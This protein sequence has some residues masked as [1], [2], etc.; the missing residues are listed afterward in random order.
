MY[1]CGFLHTDASVGIYFDLLHVY[2]CVNRMK[3]VCDSECLIDFEVLCVENLLNYIFITWLNVNIQNSHFSAQTVRC[4]S[5]FS[6][7]QHRK[8][9]SSTLDLHSNTSL[10]SSKFYFITQS[11]QIRHENVMHHTKYA[12]INAFLRSMNL[13]LE[14]I[15]EMP[16]HITNCKARRKKPR[17]ISPSTKQLELFPSFL[18]VA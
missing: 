1:V 14:W 2:F 11:S 5:L 4:F 18:P 13:K 8:G 17:T 6:S 9:M 7:S 16:F 10:Q 3:T 12:V 15:R